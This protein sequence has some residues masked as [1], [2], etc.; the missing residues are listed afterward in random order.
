MVVE[1]VVDGE[2]VAKGRPRFTMTG[3]AYTPKRTHDY[4]KKVKEAYSGE[5]F[6]EDIPLE[7]HIDA[8]FQIPKSVSKKRHEEMRRG[9][10]RPMKKPDAD[11]IAKSICD[12][13]NGVAYADDKQVIR[14]VVDKWYSDVPRAEVKITEVKW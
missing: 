1:F 9:S 7:V 4:E 2:P 3:R 14:L 10:I 11:N 13:L 6:P 12:A 5:M 8:Y